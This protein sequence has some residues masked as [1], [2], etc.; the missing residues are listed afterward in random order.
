MW[1]EN[2]GRIRCGK[3]QKCRPKGQKNE[4]KSVAVDCGKPVELLECP[5]CKGSKNLSSS[6]EDDII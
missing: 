1:R 2:W 6:N 5:R 3:T 4:Y